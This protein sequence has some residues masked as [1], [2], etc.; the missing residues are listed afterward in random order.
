L[1]CPTCCK[2]VCIECSKLAH[3]GQCKRTRKEDLKAVMNALKHEG[4]AMC[5]K[6]GFVAGRAKDGCNQIT[7]PKPCSQVF[8]F[9]CSRDW[10]LCRGLC[11][12]HG[13][14]EVLEK[15]A[16]EQSPVIENYSLVES[17]GQGSTVEEKADQEA[18]LDENQT[19]KRAPSP[20]RL[21]E[22]FTK[23][24]KTEIVEDEEDKDIDL[25][26]ILDASDDEE[27]KVV[28]DDDNEEAGFEFEDEEDEYGSDD[29]EDEE[30]DEVDEDE[31]Y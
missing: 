1:D 28:H 25:E 30:D 27:D 5:P 3:E 11:K 6:C 7:C 18:Q 23:R 16:E 8:C 21:F 12:G 20:D 26:A 14:T 24:P 10:K 17:V 4:A 29:G 22:R 31:E 15:A 2:S 9:K 19:R 13:A